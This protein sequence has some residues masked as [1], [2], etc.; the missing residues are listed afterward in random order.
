M[1]CLAAKILDV[2]MGLSKLLQVKPS[3][4]KTKL[5]IDK[6]L[7][8]EAERKRIRK[9]M[10]RIREQRERRHKEEVLRRKRGK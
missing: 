7:K 3:R 10:R 5:D 6:H 1:G 2:I 9:G 8:D 4:I